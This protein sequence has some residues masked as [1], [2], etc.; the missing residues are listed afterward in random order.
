[1]K[2]I[3]NLQFPKSLTVVALLGAMFMTYSAMAA[4]RNG[5][6][7]NKSSGKVYPAQII[8]DD[9]IGHAITSDANGAYVD[10]AENVEANV[11]EEG[12]PPGQ[13]SFF[14]GAGKD[15][16]RAININLGSRTGTNSDKV[17][18][19]NGNEV[20]CPFTTGAGDC[21][22]SVTA[23]MFIRD[24]VTADGSTVNDEGYFLTMD[25]DTTFSARAQN[26]ELTFRVG[27]QGWA[28]SFDDVTCDRSPNPEYFLE[29]RAEDSDANNTI[30]ESW[31]VGTDVDD[32]NTGTKIA[33]LAKLTNGGRVE[34][35]LGTFAL[36]FGYRIE[37]TN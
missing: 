13:F 22:G 21:A 35:I 14:T 31:N 8:F 9:A 7:G 11:P 1:M 27:R 18:D 16:T 10:G 17:L 4:P 25:A 26:F 37:L 20:E 5:G 28:L 33:C 36:S 3:E 12:T 34:A 30:R 29:L 6:N 24:P 2:T 23:N 32:S 19:S 15:A